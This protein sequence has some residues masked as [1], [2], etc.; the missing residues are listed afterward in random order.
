[1]STT[2]SYLR[3]TWCNPTTGESNEWV[4]QL[5]IQIG[6]SP[7]TNTIVLDDC[8]VSRQHAALNQKGKPVGNCGSEQHQWNIGEWSADQGYALDFGQHI[9]KLDR[10]PLGPSLGRRHPIPNRCTP[11]P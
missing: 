6:R 7:S 4:A 2:P 10:T 5:P 1:M 8:Q 3:L 9:F 11:I